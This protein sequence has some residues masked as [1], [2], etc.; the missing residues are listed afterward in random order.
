M[1]R[2]LNTYIFKRTF[3]GLLISALIIF[4]LIALV[5]FVE[6]TRDVDAETG[7]GAF[8]L[9]RLTL[10]KT[11]SLLEQTLPF[12][13]LFGT[14]GTLNGLNKRSELIAA[15]A[16]GISA[17]RYLR[18]A[19]LLAALF[20]TLWVTLANPFSGQ[21][22][23]Q[24]DDIRRA[25]GA[26]GGVQTTRV[27]L[28]EADEDTRTV[29][30]ADSANALKR[31]LT[32]VTYLAFDRDDAG[33][34][35]TRRLDAEEAAWLS[36]GFFQLSGVREWVDESYSERIPDLAVPTTITERQLL[37]R[38]GSDA[39]IRRLPP[40]WELPALIRTQA[41]AGFSTLLTRMSLWKLTALPI[42]L[43]GMALIG[44]CVS[45]RL[46]REGGTWKLILTGGVIGFFVFFASV[47]IEA[48]GEVGTI[49]PIVAA[50]TVPLVTLFIGLA[51]LAKLEDG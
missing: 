35:F 30:M 34:T 21:F 17:W 6:A 25:A 11:P 7:L 18:P 2:R 49:P 4:A 10:L 32:G 24:H 16:A 5:D 40:V 12:I 3:R 22:L 43:L 13:V 37:E 45:M 27:W 23:Q 19:L 31:R 51:Y 46:S 9:F 38:I 44:A 8:D 42:L 47:F 15:R 48:F 36:T 28:R 1:I 50:W 20:G 26:D 39:D 33:D 14:I 29:I 41:R